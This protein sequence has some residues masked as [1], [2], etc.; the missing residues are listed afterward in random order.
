MTNLVYCLDGTTNDYN[1]AYPTNVVMMHKSIAETDA[2]GDPQHVYYD[3]GVG[4]KLGQNLLGMCFGYGLMK[5][6]LQAYEDICNHYSTGDDIYIF[7]FSRG[8]YT[9]RSLAGLV[10]YVGIL[11]EPSRQNIDQAEYYYKQRLN[12]SEKHLSEFSAWRAKQCT[13]HCAN[14]IDQDFRASCAGKAQEVP[15]IIRIRY[16]GVWDTVKTIGLNERKYQWHDHDLSENVDSARHAI[17]LDERRNKFN[18]T[19]WT[20]IPILNEIARLEGREGEPY[21]QKY[22][23]G[24]HGSIGGGGPIKGLSDDVFQW[25][26]EGAEEA[27]L[28]FQK[29]VRGELFQLTPNPLDWLDNNV[30]KPMGFFGKRVSKAANFG[31]GVFGFSDRP[32]PREITNVSHTAMVR[33]FAKPELL[34]EG[35]QYRPGSLKLIGP[36]L[37]RKG[38][39][40]SE[41]DY[42]SLFES[43]STDKLASDEEKYVRIDGKRYQVHIVKL[44]ETLSLIAKEYFGDPKRWPEIYSANKAGISNPDQIYVSQRILIPLDELLPID[45][46]T[47]AVA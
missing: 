8:A 4:T 1:S 13:Q 32:G 20:N 29:S 39:P 38:S 19:E 25:V 43:I 16:V 18:I 37:K 14:K 36:L 44:G 31:I 35:V 30:G 5:N 33:Y 42:R 26:R 2:K 23:P 22:F 41:V 11:D 10:G 9:A 45:V 15:E 12:K 24:N 27:G 46:S 7:G 28:C 40:F 17:A 21:Q 47:K 34:P 3:A 6:V